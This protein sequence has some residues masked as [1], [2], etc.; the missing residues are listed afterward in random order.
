MLKS[1][2]FRAFNCLGDLMALIQPDSFF[3]CCYTNKKTLIH[4]EWVQSTT[5]QYPL[6]TKVGKNLIKNLTKRILNTFET[7]YQIL[8]LVLIFNLHNLV[9]RTV[10][11]EQHWP[12]QYKM[13]MKKPRTYNM[14][15]FLNNIVTIRFNEYILYYLPLPQVFHYIDAGKGN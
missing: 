1:Y 2:Q 10:A 7:T 5:Q 14:Q 11:Q 9:F 6:G 13:G 8:G 15:T 4:K 3:R 12:L